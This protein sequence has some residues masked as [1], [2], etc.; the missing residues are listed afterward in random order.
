[1]KLLTNLIRSRNVSRTKET[2]PRAPLPAPPGRWAPQVHPGYPVH[3]GRPPPV[4]F[5]HPPPVPVG[6]AHGDNPMQA[7]PTSQQHRQRPVTPPKARRQRSQSQHRRRRRRE[8]PGLIEQSLTMSEADAA[9]KNCLPHAAATQVAPPQAGQS[10]QDEQAMFDL[11]LRSNREKL[12]RQ[13]HQAI[14]NHDATAFFK[15]GLAALQAYMLFFLHY[16]ENYLTTA[17]LHTLPVISHSSLRSM[18]D[19]LTFTKT[20][21]RPWGD[22]KSS[23][24]AEVV[25]FLISTFVNQPSV[26]IGEREIGLSAKAMLASKIPY[27]QMFTMGAQEYAV[28]EEAVHVCEFPAQLFPGPPT[29]PNQWYIW[30]HG[31]TPRPCRDSNCWSR[32]SL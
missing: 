10:D 28:P 1:M 6:Q 24:V 2:S 26:A 3:Y 14:S 16:L 13:L 25:Q 18:S 7:R 23:Q 20:F 15:E 30:G 5:A 17:G 9:Q 21:S 31:T 12:T 8:H 4:P 27:Q 19:R 29:S 32:V 22:I 11:V